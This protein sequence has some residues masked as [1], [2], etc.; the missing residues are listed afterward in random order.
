[1]PATYRIDPVE[2]LVWSRAWGVVWNEELTAH[3]RALRADARF[4][5]DFRQLQDFRSVERV[6]LTSAG[7]RE[8]A[9]LN[10]FDRGA[11]R[12]VVVP[13]DELFG[14]ARMHEQLRKPGRDELQVFRDLVPALA[15]LGLP[16]G[17]TPPPPDPSDPVFDRARFGPPPPPSPPRLE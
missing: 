6:E 10:P 14:L 3:S 2:R 13:T 8:V 4:H 16:P 12:A 9:A 15:W 7:L 17:W 11:R 1:M 5:P